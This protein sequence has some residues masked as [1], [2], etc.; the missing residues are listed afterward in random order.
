MDYRLATEGLRALKNRGTEAEDAYLDPDDYI[1][2]E[3]IKRSPKNEWGLISQEGIRSNLPE[4]FEWTVDLEHYLKWLYDHDYITD[5]G[6]KITE[7]GSSFDRLES[8]AERRYQTFIDHAVRDSVEGKIGGGAYDYA[9][10]GAKA[11]ERYGI[12]ANEAAYEIWNN[13]TDYG[14]SPDYIFENMSELIR[15]IE[16]AYNA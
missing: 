3:T 13:L 10:I 9:V 7:V 8:R 6:R 14:R 5:E 2:L 1:V 15:I 16:E 4:S 12:S 11:M